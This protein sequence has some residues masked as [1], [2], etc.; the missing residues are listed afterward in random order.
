MVVGRVKK[1]GMDVGVEK[2]G[3]RQ[4]GGEDRDRG[5]EREGEGGRVEV[6]D[7]I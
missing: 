4:N 2:A 7:P 3:D 1:T 5:R 6:H